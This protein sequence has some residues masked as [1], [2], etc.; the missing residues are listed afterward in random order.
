MASDSK[1]KN[2]RWREE[3]TASWLTAAAGRAE[4]DPRIAAA[5]AKLADESARQAA[6]IAPSPMPPFHPP[7]RARVIAGLLKIFGPR[8][9]VPALAATKVR[10]V[11]L[12][13]ELPPGHPMPT[14]AAEI[15][16]RHR[17]GGGLRAAV[18]GAN[19]GIISNTSLVMGMTG[20]AVDNDVVFLTGV[21]GLL[22]GAFSMAAGEYVSVRTQREMLEYQIAQEREELA[23]YPEEEAEELALIYA[24]RGMAI[25]DARAFAKKIVADPDLALKVLAREELGLDPDNLASAAQAAIWSFGSFAVGAILPVAPFALGLA[26]PSAIAAGLAAVALFG[27]G[28]ATSLFSGRNA[29]LGGL[30]MLAIGTAAGAAT[31][32][33]GGLFGV[34]AP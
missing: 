31:Y 9:M 17:R 6:L 32:M 21:A 3:M 7:L 28:A 30:R 24:A 1:A 16:A 29:L 18:F 5:F 25:D 11:S 33:I 2:A 8:R 20:A 19:D 27:V 14:N 34:A 12:Y 23:E 26:A 13:S 10:G 22:A 4:K 15:G